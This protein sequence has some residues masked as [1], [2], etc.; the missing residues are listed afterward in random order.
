MKCYRPFSSKFPYPNNVFIGR[1]K[2][3]KKLVELVDFSNSTYEIISIVGSPGIGKSSLAIYIGNEMI[4]NGAVLHYVDMAEFPDG[5]QLKQVL[6]E[7]ILFNTAASEN[8]T[9]EKLLGWVG[10]RYWNNLIVLDNCDECIYSQKRAFQEAVEGI[11]EFSDNNIKFLTSSREETAFFENYFVHK[12]EPLSEESACD[13]LDHKS[14]LA[15]NETEKKLIAELTGEIPL[16][17]KIVASLLSIK[18]SP[19]TPAE[20]IGKLKNNPIPALSD[21]RLTKQLNHSI[22]VSYNYLDVKLQKIGRYLAHFPGSFAKHDSIEFLCEVFNSTQ[23]KK[24]LIGS[25]VD[26]LA[27]LVTRSLLEFDLSTGRYHFHRLI[28]EFFIFH[29]PN[30]EKHKFNLLFQKQIGMRLCEM[31]KNYLKSPKEVLKVI[32]VERHNFQYFFSIYRIPCFVNNKTHSCKYSNSAIS[33]LNQA[34]AIKFIGCRFSDQELIVAFQNI[35]DILRTHLTKSKKVSKSL[36]KTRFSNFVISIINLASL[37]REKNQVTQLFVEAIDIVEK[38]GDLMP[39]V[40]NSKYIMFY[41]KFL[42]YKPELSSDS[43]KLY[44]ARILRK[45]EHSTLECDVDESRC[46]FYDIGKSYFE[47]G[48]YEKSAECYENSVNGEIFRVYPIP[49]QVDILISLR[50]SYLQMNQSAKACEIGEKIYER[51]SSMCNQT[52]SV[53]YSYVR[54]YRSYVDLLNLCEGFKSDVAELEEKMI[55]ALTDLGKENDNYTILVAYQLTKYYYESGNFSRVIKVALFALESIEYVE[56]ITEQSMKPKTVEIYM[57]L[58][59]STYYLKNF[60]E[61]NK[62]FVQTIDFLLLYNLTRF[63][64]LY[65][66]TCCSHLVCMGNF[67]YLSNCYSSVFY[68]L[69]QEICSY[70][71][72]IMYLVFVVPSDGVKTGSLHEPELPLEV[73]PQVTQFSKL[74]SMLSNDDYGLAFAYEQIFH[75]LPDFNILY[76]LMDFFCPFMS[77][78][79][80]YIRYFF[81]FVSVFLR[82]IFFYFTLKFCCHALLQC[83][84]YISCVTLLFLL[85]LHVIVGCILTYYALCL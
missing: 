83:F 31:N 2:E 32:D 72:Y 77:P 41:S 44:H 59:K 85:L 65:F 10:D 36:M 17:L 22:L 63:Y 26:S 12:L 53:V 20:I 43:L 38:Y 81:Y 67:Q 64:S 78:F 13:L 74:T 15:L 39:G 73:F 42:E 3:V 6:A 84:R 18:L 69:L 34:L 37:M 28:K 70:F 75:I 4:L 60:T 66:T 68:R 11:L 33:C 50:M 30:S 14:S 47:L 1:E 48:E 45:T 21:S 19:P 46:D 9:F 80:S 76:L 55:E 40:T 82:V 57:I 16:A 25:Y 5:Q 29:S 52:S 7:K 56:N 24:D 79:M 27:E 61:A 49:F 23:T 71:L 58:S 51:F 8:I 62:F 35:T 54:V